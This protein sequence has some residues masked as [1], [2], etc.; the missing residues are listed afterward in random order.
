[1]EK[2]NNKKKKNPDNKEEIFMHKTYNLYI[3]AIKE[4]N[5]G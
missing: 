3:S 2:N 4:S 5:C 1:M